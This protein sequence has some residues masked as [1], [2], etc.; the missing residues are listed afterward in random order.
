MKKI[1]LKAKLHTLAKRKFCLCKRHRTNGSFKTK[2]Q[3]TATRTHLVPYLLGFATTSV[4]RKEFP[5]EKPTSSNT[6]TA[7]DIDGTNATALSSRADPGAGRSFVRQCWE[8][9][10]GDG[11]GVGDRNRD[12]F[13]TDRLLD[14]T[15]QGPT[16]RFR[17]MPVSA[18]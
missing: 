10:G 15:E 6:C 18:G 14:T 8:G 17:R 1:D 5:V 16:S 11:R 12:R 9:R 3:S 2:A 4:E 13:G 7:S